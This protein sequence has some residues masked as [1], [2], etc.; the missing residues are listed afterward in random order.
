[1]SHRPCV[2][3]WLAA[4]LT[5]LTACSQAADLA[6]TNHASGDTLRHSVVLLRGT[7][8]PGTKTLEIQNAQ[9]PSGA[10]PVVAAI[11]ADRFKSLVELIP[12]K[13]DLELRTEQDGR[14]LRFTLHYRPQTNPYYVR[15]VWMTSSDGETRFAAPDDKVPQ[16]YEARLRTAGLLMQAFTA[17]KMNEAGFGQRTFRLERDEAGQVVVHTWKAPKSTQHYYDLGDSGR[18]W[19]AV[20]RWVNGQ[21]PDR[22]AKNVVLASFTRKDPKSGRMR[23]HTALGG[24]NLGLFGSA[25]VFSWPRHVQDAIPSFQDASRF[26]TSR[27]HDD[28]VGRSTIWGLASTTIGATLHETCHPFGLPHCTDRFCIMTRGFDHFNRAFTFYDPP[29]GRHP[30]PRFFDDD[31]EARFAPVS[32]SY[33]R[34]SRWFQLD[35]TA[36]PEDSRPKITIDQEAGTV[37]VEAASG[38]PWVGFWV[39]DNIHAYRE[40]ADRP[41]QVTLSLAEIGKALAGK[42]LSRVSALAS[43]G[44][45]ARA[46]P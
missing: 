19:G 36:Y 37:T 10:R 16:D 39:G 9:N 2:P 26:D 18:Y 25:S 43:N 20:H 28:S 15:L 5:L 11:H 33:L 29:S 38:V 21:H 31:E 42:P 13:N 8:P 7:L 3:L 24:G 14:P 12:G 17:E 46:D 6:I 22:H 1:M 44:L 35:E 45:E 4:T 30:L 40:F 32:A 34:W 27:V 23:G 41:K